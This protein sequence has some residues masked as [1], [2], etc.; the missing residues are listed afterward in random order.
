M[1]P[2][3]SQQSA[4]SGPGSQ[5]QRGIQ[6]YFKT[7][8]SASQ[9][10]AA[11]RGIVVEERAAKRLKSEPQSRVHSSP[12][13]RLTSPAPSDTSS[14]PALTSPPDGDE[15]MDD[16]AALATAVN[17]KLARF[18]V[19]SAAPSSAG[20]TRGPSP[21]GLGESAIDGDEDGLT[22]AV[23]ASGVGAKGQGRRH[24]EDGSQGGVESSPPVQLNR[25][26]RGR[27]APTVEES[28]DQ[29]VVIDLRSPDPAPLGRTLNYEPQTSS[30]LGREPSAFRSSAT[31][32]AAASGTNTP[33]TSA[34]GPTFPAA[35]PIPYK[36]ASTGAAFNTKEFAAFFAQ[37]GRG[38]GS[39]SHQQI[40]TAWTDAGGD[41]AEGMGKLV[42]AQARAGGS[43]LRTGQMGPPSLGRTSSAEAA[44]S[45]PPQFGSRQAVNSKEKGEW[46]DKRR[47]DPEG[48]YNQLVAMQKGGKL[49]ESHL[50]TLKALHATHGKGGALPSAPRRMGAFAAA[51]SQSAASGFYGNSTG[52]SRFGVAPAASGSVFGRPSLPPARA[53]PTPTPTP[54]PTPAPPPPKLK[55]GRIKD[56]SNVELQAASPP[57][58]TKPTPEV[59]STRPPP[60]VREPSPAPLKR[61]QKKKP[62]ANDSEDEGGW[63][64]GSGESYDKEDSSADWVQKNADALGF[65]NTADKAGLT[66]LVG[67]TLEQAGLLAN[68]RPFA[69]PDEF[70][71]KTRKQK[72]LGNN[73]FD[74][75]LDLQDGMK[76][77]DKILSNCE[78]IGKQLNKV[79]RIW[80]GEVNP[81]EAEAATAPGT[82]ADGDVGLNLVA[83]KEEDVVKAVETADDPAVKEAFDGYLTRQPELVSD[84]IQLKDYQLLGVNWLH[85]LYRRQLSCILAD[86]MGLGK[87]A[88]VI[89]LLAHLKHSG[90]KGPH[91]VIVPSS[92]LENWMREFSVFAPS[93]VAKSYYGSMADRAE[94]RHELREMDNL[95]VV[96][97]TYNIVGSTADDIKF[98][99][100]RMSWNVAVFDEGHQLKNS[101]SKK[102]KDLM[103]IPVK[104]RV[105]LTGTPLQNNLQELVSLLSFILPDQFRDASDS[106]RAIFKVA[107]GASGNLL[108]RERTS[109]AKKMMTPFVLR[110]KKA[111]VL[112]DLPAKHVRVHECGMTDL[113]REVY[114]EAMMRGKRALLTLADDDINAA[115]AEA[116]A[117]AEDEPKKKG[118]GKAAATKSGKTA[119]ASSSSHVLMDLRKAANHP[120]LFR[121]LFDDKK[122]KLMAREC[123]KELDFAESDP[124]LIV[125][126]ME[127]M[128][129]FELHRFCGGYKY[130]KKFCLVNEEW[131]SAGKI[132]E[133]QEMLP[134]LKA[135]G[136]R[137]LLFSQFTM[138]LDILQVVLD[139]MGIRYI[140]LTGQTNVTDRQGLVDDYN[141][142]PD[143]TVFRTHPAPRLFRKKIFR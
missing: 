36:V 104:W 10:Q 66:E 91:L 70:R 80:V 97:T 101:A 47:V 112:K 60:R 33:P 126:D 83:V 84:K 48:Y 52:T 39:F 131:M 124:A 129:D 113:Q 17:H 132:H 16:D 41:P 88:Q 107:P 57:R 73:L 62:A 77:V 75:Y 139:T 50:P 51:H 76:E 11:A 12:G 115:A 56:Y 90:E 96:V 142:D 85:L 92:T 122:L 13:S 130:L 74:A 68:L 69:T 98:F 40:R 54:T 71:T 19:Q 44:S 18:S 22:Q 25:I 117:D 58:S 7:A 4:G 108:S 133:L 114:L 94:I 34:T 111:Q 119:D 87:T 61:L 125:E 121:R 42:Q 15:Q 120:M 3:A 5:T 29:S 6:S 28:P 65:F 45:F 138:V 24:V 135:N 134:R 27:P 63:S 103:V 100:K 64:D 137:V 128:T 127:V 30:P 32:S 105:L 86:E 123:L 8:P 102:H 109:R 14:A 53:S 78:A 79:M 89:S 118:R 55:T 81:A 116:D 43:S 2:S 59:A 99:K 95:D 35:A 23:V 1:S 46:D 140:K 37:A 20:S 110:R 143:I 26:R 141:N 82:A 72:G 31:P 49:H 136:D 21:T 67:C 38:A 106:M 93:L 9:A